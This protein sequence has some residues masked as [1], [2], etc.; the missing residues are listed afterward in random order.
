VDVALAQAE[1]RA[2]R[3][4][5]VH[6][7]PPEPDFIGFEAGPGVVREQVA[8]EFH[9]D[10]RA[11]ESVA[12]TLRA[13]GLEVATHL[14]QAPT[15]EAIL[16]QAAEHDADLIIMG[17]HGRGLLHNVLVG[18]VSEGVLRGTECPLLLVP[19]RTRAVQ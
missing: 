14:V 13:A 7:V 4:R 12:E 3:A 10:R 1:G 17:T 15:V 19:A 6:A 2:V 9:D 11:I 16:K 8:K 18:S 5:L